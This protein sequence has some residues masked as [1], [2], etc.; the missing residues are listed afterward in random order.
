MKMGSV[1][2]KQVHWVQSVLPALQH[3]IGGFGSL[4]AKLPIW[5]CSEFS[6]RT[7]VYVCFFRWWC[8]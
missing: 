4:K 3:F 6:G 7:E 2:A 8:I 1:Y 5:E